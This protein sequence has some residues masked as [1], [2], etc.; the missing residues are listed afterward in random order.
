MR[1]AIP[2]AKIRAAAPGSR[3]HGDTKVG[4]ALR[5]RHNLGNALR[6]AAHLLRVVNRGSADDSSPTTGIDEDVELWR[7]ET[8]LCLSL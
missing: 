8:T 3:S 7:R 5:L 2:R 4:A 6:Q 1:L